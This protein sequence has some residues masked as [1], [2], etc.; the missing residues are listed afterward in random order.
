MAAAAAA[1]NYNDGDE[2]TPYLGQTAVYVHLQYVHLIVSAKPVLV[3]SYRTCQAFELRL[4]LQ[5]ELRI[6]VYI[7]V[8]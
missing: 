2:V 7:H 6:T 5:Q 8:S 4:P 3:E 1:A